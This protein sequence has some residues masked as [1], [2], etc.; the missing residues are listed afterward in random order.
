MSWVVPMNVPI[1]LGMLASRPTP[2]NIALWQWI[3]QSYNA[4]WNYSNRNATSEFSTKDLGLSYG[5]AVSVSV[6]I[7]IIG[8][9]I[10]NKFSVASGSIAKKRF[11]N[12]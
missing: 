10:A 3:N 1:I 8:G 6:G 7:A 4:G 5:V 9:K 11:I 2:F 12:G